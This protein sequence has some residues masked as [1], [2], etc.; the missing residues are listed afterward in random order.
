[1]V[2]ISH[3]KRLFSVIIY[4]IDLQHKPVFTLIKTK[5]YEVLH[6][7]Y[8]YEPIIC[9]DVW[10]PYKTHNH[11]FQHFFSRLKELYGKA[12][13]TRAWNV[14]RKLLNNHSSININRTF[15]YSY[16]VCNSVLKKWALK[17]NSYI[18]H[19]SV[20]LNFLVRSSSNVTECFRA[21]KSNVPVMFAK[22]S[23]VMLL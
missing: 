19:R 15:V 4:D 8:K 22:L 17:H 10:H 1:M 2:R 21:F 6:E 20:F 9:L 14:L 12:D 13:S 5:C 18:N 7:V 23:N 3:V 11:S 16:Q